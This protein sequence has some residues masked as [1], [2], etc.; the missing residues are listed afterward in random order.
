MKYDEESRWSELSFSQKALVLTGLLSCLL[1]L[2]GLVSLYWGKRGVG[3]IEV[4]VLVPDAAGAEE[5]IP[6]IEDF[7]SDSGIY[8][9]PEFVRIVHE[10]RKFLPSRAYSEIPPETMQS[11]EGIVEQYL[12]DMRARS[13][14][15]HLFDALLF[16]YSQ[17]YLELINKA[18]IIKDGNLLTIASVELNLSFAELIRTMPFDETWNDDALSLVFDLHSRLQIG[19]FGKKFSLVF[20]SLPELALLGL[21]LGI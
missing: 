20:G 9:D 8:D 1:V 17:K 2:W 19:E 21:P 5:T 14:I 7:F 3:P 11:I 12:S 13:G 18:R 15:P 6:S 10:V 16:S 4:E